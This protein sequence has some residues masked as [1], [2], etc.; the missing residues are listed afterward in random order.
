MPTAAGSFGKQRRLKLDLFCLSPATDAIL[1]LFDRLGIAQ[2][3]SKL[4]LK[5]L[6]LDRILF[7]LHTHRRFR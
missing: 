6:H 7:V 3:G 4:K 1:M 2:G 5:A